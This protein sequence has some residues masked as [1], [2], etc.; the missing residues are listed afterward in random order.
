MKRSDPYLET[1]LRNGE[2]LGKVNITKEELRESIGA[3]S[4]ADSIDK[5]P[6]GTYLLFAEFDFEGDGH[7]IGMRLTPCAKE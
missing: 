1:L 7:F 5:I 4:N 2:F 6:E 3:N